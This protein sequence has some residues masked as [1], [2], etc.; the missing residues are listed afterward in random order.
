[1]LMASWKKYTHTHAHTNKQK[2]IINFSLSLCT[3]VHTH[4][5]AQSS[6]CPSP[7]GAHRRWSGQPSM[8]L[9][10]GP[11]RRHRLS[12]LLT[13]DDSSAP[14]LPGRMHCLELTMPLTLQMARESLLI[15]RP[16]RWPCLKRI[17]YGAPC[18]WCSRAVGIDPD[19]ACVPF[20]ASLTLF[21]GGDHSLPCNHIVST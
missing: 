14:G 17:C 2:T 10:L 12:S 15:S 7:H 19:T 18:T 4:P 16:K 20:Y 21:N 5:P 9:A 13:G 3:R 6:Y 8:T 1:M 11:G